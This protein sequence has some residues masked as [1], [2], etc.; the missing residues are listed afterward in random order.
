MQTHKK[1][2]LNP[3]KN[4]RSQH[5]AKIIRNRVEIKFEI[6]FGIKLIISTVTPKSD[7]LDLQRARS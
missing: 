4:L 7:G 5:L 6:N 3:S 2:K 1:V